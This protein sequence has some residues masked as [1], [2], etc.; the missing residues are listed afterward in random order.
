MKAARCPAAE[1]QIWRGQSRQLARWRRSAFGSV[2]CCRG[3]CLPP[4]HTFASTMARRGDLRRSRLNSRCLRGQ[5]MSKWPCSGPITAASKDAGPTRSPGTSTTLV[6]MVVSAS[7]STLRCS[8]ATCGAGTCDGSE[9]AERQIGSGPRQVG[10]RTSTPRRP[11][12]PCMSEVTTIR[13]VDNA[14]AAM[15]RSWAPRGRPAL[16]TATSSS[17]CARATVRS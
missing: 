10:C 3:G 14:V 7:G 5:C 17:V 13:P 15:M 12:N 16:R 9:H 8:T 6:R 4:I 11:S 2:R 1:R